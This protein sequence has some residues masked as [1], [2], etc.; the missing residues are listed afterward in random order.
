MGRFQKTVENFVCDNCGQ[1]V[2]GSGY[3]NH[4]PNCL[5]S[6]HVDIA[7]G[8]REEECS[9]LMK[10]ILAEKEGQDIYITHKCEKCGFERR[11]RTSE[12]DNFDK[13]LE[14]MK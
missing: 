4:C 6:K 13:V 12:D 14:L 2:Q 11:N 1:K 7:P 9:G 3:T 5:W 8:D 10:P